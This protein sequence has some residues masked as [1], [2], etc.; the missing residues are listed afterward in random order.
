MGVLCEERNNRSY[1]AHSRIKL[2][3]LSLARK[4]VSETVESFGSKVKRIHTDDFIISSDEKIDPTLIKK[5][6]YKTCISTRLEV[7]KNAR[8]S[9]KNYINVTLNIT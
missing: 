6:L 4:T 3:L 7:K 9:I 5:I 1:G 8:C 2:F